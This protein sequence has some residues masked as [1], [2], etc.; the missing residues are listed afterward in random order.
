VEVFAAAVLRDPEGSELN[1]DSFTQMDKC[2]PNLA[3]DVDFDLIT[4]P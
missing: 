1:V 2:S 3:V 4:L